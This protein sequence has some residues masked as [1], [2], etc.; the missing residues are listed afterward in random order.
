MHLLSCSYSVSIKI[1]SSYK[2]S[3]CL[4][5]DSTRHLFMSSS[6]PACLLFVSRSTFHVHDLPFRCR[7][8]YSPR[9]FTIV[10][11]VECRSRVCVQ[12]WHPSEEK[13]EVPKD[14]PLYS[15]PNLLIYMLSGIEESAKQ[16]LYSPVKARSA[17]RM[18]M[19]MSE[20][21]RG[22]ETLPSSISI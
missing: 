13:N 3:M 22:A 14:M 10:Q 8:E 21:H 4:L 17:R 19:R 5:Y 16:T 6:L 11:Y 12:R 18:N 20:V 1:F 2:S 7:R 15:I 9:R